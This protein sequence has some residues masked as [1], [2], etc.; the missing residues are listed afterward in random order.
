MQVRLILYSL[1]IEMIEIIFL[2]LVKLSIYKE[3]VI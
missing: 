3:S 1:K 2:I